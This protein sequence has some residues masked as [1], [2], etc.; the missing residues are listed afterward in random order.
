MLFTYSPLSLSENWL[1][2]TIIDLLSD[3]M[4][5]ILDGADVPNWPN[6]IPA[7]YRAKLRSRH[8]IKKRLITFWEKY[9]DL[10][11]DTQESLLAA[12]EQQTSLPDILVNENECISIQNF[13]AEIQDAADK[14][15]RFLFDEQITSLLLDSGE[16]L[17]DFHY[18]AIYE[19]L[20]ARLCP[21]CGLEPF[22]SRTSGPRHP[23]DHYLPISKYPFVGADFRNITPMCDTCNT[24]YKGDKDILLD[25]TG[26]RKR[27]VNPYAGPT[28]KISLLNSLPFEGG[29][30]NGIR[31]PIW[32]IQFVNGPIEQAEN[33][34]RIFK[35]RERYKEHVLDMDFRDWLNHFA[36]WCQR[37]EQVGSSINDIV[38]S[39]PNYI[40]NVIQ[41]G[42]ADRA[43]LKV[44]VF[45]L[46]Q[47]ECNHPERGEDMKNFLALLVSNI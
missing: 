27:C 37:S 21:F 39:L 47:H 33:W 5:S 30:S 38:A 13:T 22:R 35:I 19:N 24:G 26:Q 46:I 1:N 25:D 14:L 17:R 45:R 16:C 36:V 43:F 11:R 42:F 9:A 44:E 41:D 15:F 7:G 32:D 18:N 28:F 4:Q 29:V 8:G 6:D 3:G 20:P 12:V 31:L 2:S 40:D 10:D 34:D 23:L